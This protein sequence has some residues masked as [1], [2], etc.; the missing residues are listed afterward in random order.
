MWKCGNVESIFKLP[1]LSFLLPT[2]YF[3]LHISYFS[4]SG[5]VEMWSTGQ[6]RAANARLSLYPI[7]KMYTARNNNDS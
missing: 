1:A 4:I 6:F 3:L 2:S 7:R 5:N